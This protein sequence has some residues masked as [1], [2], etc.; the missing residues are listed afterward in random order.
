[1][2][3]VGGLRMVLLTTLLIVGC[4]KTS[5]HDRI[6]GKWTPQ[7]VNGRALPDASRSQMRFE[8]LRDGTCRRGDEGGSFK[9]VDASTIQ[10]TFGNHSEVV[11]IE[12]KGDILI[13]RMDAGVMQAKRDE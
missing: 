10:T 12:I 2:R 9:V 4:G 5:L 13:M 11:A 3:L 1:M 8:F 6:S 7:S